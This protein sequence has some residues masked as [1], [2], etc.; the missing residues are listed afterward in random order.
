[1]TSDQGVYWINKN[2]SN[3]EKRNNTYRKNILCSPYPDLSGHSLVFIRTIDWRIPNDEGRIKNI[4]NIFIN[5]LKS[6]FVTR[7]SSFF[8]VPTLYLPYLSCLLILPVCPGLQGPVEFYGAFRRAIVCAASAI[9]AFV[10]MKNNG[11]H[12]LF[13][14]RDIHVDLA[15][16]DTSVTPGAKFRVKN[17][18]LIWR[19]NIGHCH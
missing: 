9:P 14:M 12:T 10:G 11:W 1:M 18:R 7:H 3:Q 19:D 15:C 2:Q 6:L 16:L 17:D 5:I 4:W 13:G 8:I